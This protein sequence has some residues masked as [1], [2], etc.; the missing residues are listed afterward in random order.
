[1]T[2]IVSLLLLLAAFSFIAYPVLLRRV[3]PAEPVPDEHLKEL[4]S[5]RIT[6]YSMLKE[7]EFDYNSGILTEEDYRDLENKYKSK[8]ISILKGI[9]EE[10]ETAGQMETDIEKQVRKLRGAKGPAADPGA[11]I[12]RQVQ[13]LRRT[14]SSPADASDEIEEQVRELRQERGTFCPQCGAKSQHGDRFC[15]QCGAKLD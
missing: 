11:E 9:D 2:E 14:K 3:Q 15:R 4:Q 8:A 5:K 6:T 13:K 12:E 7:L 1:M 10:A